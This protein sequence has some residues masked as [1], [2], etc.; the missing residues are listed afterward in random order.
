MDCFKHSSTAS[1]SAHLAIIMDDFGLDGYARWFLLME[2]VAEKM[3]KG[4][5]QV[6]ERLLARKLRGDREEITAF[7]DLIVSITG[8]KYKIEDDDYIIEMPEISPVRTKDSAAK[9]KFNLEKI[10]AAYPKRRGK[11]DGM[12]RLA[13]QLKTEGQYDKFRQA[14]WNYM[15][16]C[17]AEEI[18]P[19]YIMMWSTFSNNWEE[20]LDYDPKKKKAETGNS[21]EA[22]LRSVIPHCYNLM[23]REDLEKYKKEFSEKELVAIGQAGGLTGIAGAENEYKLSASI[24]AVVEML[25]SN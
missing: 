11:K 9:C 25:K 2:L 20:W 3:V 21:V 7:L 18:E 1:R 6:S 12:R 5:A 24:K 4:Q 13:S 8:V 16:H 22:R 19:K 17:D 14:T 15:Q 10:Y 23:P